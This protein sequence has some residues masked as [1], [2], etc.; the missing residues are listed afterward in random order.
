MTNYKPHYACFHCRKAFKRKHL[1]DL[2]RQ[3]KSPEK[4]A[5]CP[6]CGLLMADMGLDFEAPKKDNVK[7]WA[8]I[9]TLYSVGI[10]FHSCGCTGPG[11]IPNSKDR[12]ISYF[13]EVRQEYERNLDFWRQRE[14]PTDRPGIDRDNSK[15]WRYISR[16]P[17]ELR[18]SRG[19]GTVTNEE[20]KQ[21]WIGRL[22]EID[23]KIAHLNQT[24][25]G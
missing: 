8:H 6:N 20:A 24:E 15:N 2:G 13:E 5:K 14:E 22:K 9:K 17:Y 4:E 7:D 18:S 11:Y 21:Y 23:H 12:L 3:D 19:K 10:T 25:E 1:I 16:V